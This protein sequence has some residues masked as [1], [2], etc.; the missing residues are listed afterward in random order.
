MRRVENVGHKLYMDNFFPSPDL[1]NN[2][3]SRKTHC[4]GTGDSIERACHRNLERLKLT[5]GDI[6]MRVRGNLTAVIWKDK[7]RKHV[8]KCAPSTSRGQFL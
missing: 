5:Q 8:D 2:L 1:F 7:R 4:C 6:R 3:H